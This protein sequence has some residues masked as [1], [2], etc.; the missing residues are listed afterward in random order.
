MS[1]WWHSVSFWTK[2]KGT[3]VSIG[4]GSEIAL[5]VGDSS[6]VW[7][8]IVLGATILGMLITNW[9]EDKNNNGIVD[10]FEKK[11]KRKKKDEQPPVQ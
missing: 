2:L 9:I 10:I 7:K 4:V 11:P 8:Y 1:K 3:L 6:H 5:F